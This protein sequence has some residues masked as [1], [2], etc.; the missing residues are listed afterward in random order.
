MNGLI[1]TI[2]SIWKWINNNGVVSSLVAAAIIAIAAVIWRIVKKATK[3]VFFL[4][5]KDDHNREGWGG[6]L[7][8]ALGIRN[9]MKQDFPEYKDYVLIQYG[10]SVEPDSNMPNDYD[11]IVLMLGI[12]KNNRRSLHNKGT[13]GYDGILPKENRLEIDIVYRDYL[14]FLFAASAGMPYENSV[15]ENGKV[16]YGN[17]G[18]FQWLKNITLN[19]MYDRD[20]LIR[21]FQDKIASE[22]QEYDKA[23]RVY[24]KYNTDKYYVIRAGYYYITSILQ[25]KHIKNFEKVIF[26]DSIVKLA[27]VRSFSEDFKNENVKLKYSMLVECLKRN[28][29]V[30]EISIEDIQCIL[31]EL[32]KMEE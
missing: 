31:E 25:L 13:N 14:S 26:Q 29:S 27:K 11:F 24:R 21:R 6:D 18:Y 1:T 23:L 20:F 16:I 15:I 32:E 10:S 17:V 2:V 9:E 3:T 4:L 7:A 28:I 30:D 22:K 19:H 12:P 8:K 5:I